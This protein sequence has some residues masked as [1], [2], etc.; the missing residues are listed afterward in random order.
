[1]F[2]NVTELAELMILGLFTAAMTLSA[3]KTAFSAYLIA[4]SKSS[5]I[6]GDIA[7]N[8]R[9]HDALVK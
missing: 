4:L 9:L 6:V 5:V 7:A 3:S 8:D 2:S 1:M